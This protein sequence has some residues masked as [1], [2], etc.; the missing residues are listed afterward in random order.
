M[1]KD[2]TQEKKEKVMSKVDDN[3]ENFDICM[4][5]NCSTCPSYSKESG[6]ALFCARG[7]S[8]TEVNKKGCNCPECPVWINYGLSGT[9]YCSK[10]AA[11]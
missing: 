7:K 1:F 9:Y 6:E 8:K 2:L 3:K 5:G 11:S 4:Q 10:G